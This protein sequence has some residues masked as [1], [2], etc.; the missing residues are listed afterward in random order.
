MIDANDITGLI[1]AGGRGSRM[2][3]VDKGLQ[4][5]RRKVK[6]KDLF[7][8]ARDGETVVGANSGGAV[9]FD[10]NQK[11]T[12]PWSK[13]KPEALFKMGVFADVVLITEDFDATLTLAVLAC[14]LNQ[15]ESQRRFL[16]IAE[17]L[18]GDDESRANVIKSLFGK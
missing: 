2:G 6:A 12:V 8:D 14:E 4:A 15:L 5:A 1:L 17:G 9:V 13:A 10:G 16:G 3:G 11:V 18:A 7:P